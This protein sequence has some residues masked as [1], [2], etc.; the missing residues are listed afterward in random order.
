MWLSRLA[1]LTSAVGQLKTE[2]SQWFSSSLQAGG[3]KTP[4]EPAF[5]SECSQ[6]GGVL[7]SSWEGQPFCSIQ[8]L[9]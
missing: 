4:E 7:F 6:A 2:E 8:A 3:L 9:T 5:W 1:S